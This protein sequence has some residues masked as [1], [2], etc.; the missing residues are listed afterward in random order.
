[1]KKPLIGQYKVNLDTGHIYIMG[2]RASDRRVKEQ[3]SSFLEWV[4]DM[5]KLERWKRGCLGLPW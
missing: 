5:V 2:G 1:M 3:Q 4:E